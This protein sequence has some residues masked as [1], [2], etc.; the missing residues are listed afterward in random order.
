MDPTV[1][2]RLNEEVALFYYDIDDSL[3]LDIVKVK[4]LSCGPFL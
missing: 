4:E 2:E 3:D 1:L